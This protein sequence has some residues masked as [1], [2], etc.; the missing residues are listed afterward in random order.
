MAPR[1]LREWI[2]AGGGAQDG[3][4]LPCAQSRRDR[5]GFGQ[6]PPAFGRVSARRPGRGD[7]R[8]RRPAELVQVGRDAPQDPEDAGPIEGDEVAPAVGLGQQVHHHWLVPV[9]L[10]QPVE[11]LAQCPHLLGQPG[12]GRGRPVAPPAASSASPVAGAATGQPRSRRAFRWAGTSPAAGSRS[13][14]CT[15]ARLRPTAAAM[16][17]KD[18]PCWWADSTAHTRFTSAAS[19]RKAAKRSRSRSCCSR[20]Q[21]SR[22]S[23][24]VPKGASV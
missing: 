20:R 17:R 22:N 5:R 4:F 2:E 9:E 3:P 19:K 12:R 14:W 10:L 7:P 21:R 13:S 24:T 15:R 23:S 11:A 18:N 1:P 16:L 6:P 8:A